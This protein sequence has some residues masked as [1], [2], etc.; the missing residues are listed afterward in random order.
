MDTIDAYSYADHAHNYAQLVNCTQ[1]TAE[2][3]QSTD[4]L[5]ISQVIVLLVQLRQEAYQHSTQLQN[6]FRSS[7]ARSLPPSISTVSELRRRVHHQR[8]VG[9]LQH[10]PGIGAR[11]FVASLLAA[12]CR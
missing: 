3:V 12:G 1:H 5:S 9:R 6:R 7:L 11:D 4:H 8:L 10:V 2:A